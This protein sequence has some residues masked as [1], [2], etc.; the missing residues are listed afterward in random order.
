MSAQGTAPSTM[1][2][3]HEA[4]EGDALEHLARIGLVA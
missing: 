1:G 4:G 2:A 3:A